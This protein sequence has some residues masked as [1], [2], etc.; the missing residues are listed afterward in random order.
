MEND[1]KCLICEPQDLHFF[2]R[3]CE[4][5]QSAMFFA[6]RT[7]LTGRNTCHVDDAV[8][9]ACIAIAENIN[10]IKMRIPQNKLRAF[11]IRVVKNKAIDIMRREKRRDTLPLD[12]TD[13]HLIPDP[14]DEIIEKED[15]E[16]L[17]RAVMRLD[18]KYRTVL[19]AQLKN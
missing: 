12:D 9:N 2:L 4:E 17:L 16:N 18:E 7:I 15:Y 6:A 11:I 14:L 8:Q 10:L 1:G 5:H 19:E 3:L 13:Y